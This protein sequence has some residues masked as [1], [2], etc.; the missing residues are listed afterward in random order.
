MGQER[1]DAVGHTHRP[2]TTTFQAPE[3]GTTLNR[4]QTSLSKVRVVHGANEQY[5]ENLSGKN[6]GQIRKSLREAFNIPGDA[7]ALISGKEVGDDFVLEGGMSLE[8]VKDA[9][10]K[11]SSVLH[12]TKVGIR[13]LIRRDMP[14]VLQIEQGSFESAWTEEDFLTCLRQR[15]CI[16]MVAELQ[17]ERE[18]RLIVGYMVYELG[19]KGLNL[20]NFAT[21]PQYRRQGVGKAMINRLQDKLSQQRRTQISLIVRDANLKAQLFFKSQGFRAIKVHKNYYPDVDEDGYEMIYSLHGG[22]NRISKYYEELT[23]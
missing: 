4:A 19:K 15:N 21:H 6:V 14:E 3:I 2:N 11:G 8:F 12:N 18:E 10:V 23:A 9:G 20:I 17:V 16:G 13:W 5:F 1:M 22:E 7:S